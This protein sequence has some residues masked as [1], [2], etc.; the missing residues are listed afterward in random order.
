M[1]RL[2]LHI[3]D[4]GLGGAERVTLDWLS[5]LQ[6]AGHEVWLVL[7][8]GG[9]HDRFFTA[10]NGI[11]VL[12]APPTKR[13]LPL[14][15]ALWLR[16]CLQRIRP[17]CVIGITTRPALNL[18]LASVGRPWPVLVAERNYPPAKPLPLV[19]GMLRRW[20]YPQAALHL[21]QTERI[22]GWLTQQGLARQQAQQLTCVCFSRIC[23]VARSLAYFLT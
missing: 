12:G 19:W 8:S 5:W 3:H 23:S 10:P 7:G 2:V 22:G 20:L 14:P 21:V 1:A 16:R 9:D 11:Q 15:T 18:L 13:L 4:L 6:Q 17:D